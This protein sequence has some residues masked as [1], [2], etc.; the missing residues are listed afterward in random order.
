MTDQPTNHDPAREHEVRAAL[1]TLADAPGR[2]DEAAAWDR[3]QAGITTR[4]RTRRLTVAGISGAAA[5]A[6][7]VAAVLM[8]GSDDDRRSVEVGPSG[9]ATTEDDGATTSEPRMPEPGFPSRPLAV[10]VTEGGEGG[11]SRLDLY[12]ADT[13]QLV[14]QGLASSFHSISEVSFSGDGTVYFTEELGDSSTVRAVVWDGTGEPATPFEAGDETSGPAL[15]PDGSTFA[16]VHQGVTTDGSEIVLVDT[17][18][19]DRRALRWAEEDG[20]SEASSLHGLEWS[21]DGRRLLFVVVGPEDSTVMVLP[22]DATSLGD[23]VPVDGLS[24]FRAHWSGPEE[25]VALHECCRPD[26]AEPKELRRVSLDGASTTI[27]GAGAPTDFD[28]DASGTIAIAR[29][30][31]TVALVAPDGTVTDIALE[32][33]ALGIGL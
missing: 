17:A 19:G 32:E 31:G 33:P 21:P 8:L 14:T 25:L 7:L 2:P 10:V 11:A 1:Q 22:A 12:D 28:V 4:Q 9:T 13:G 23:A 30:E 24:A 15:S 27:D 5:A 20:A 3:V 29:A 18:T 26:F 6:A 16:Y